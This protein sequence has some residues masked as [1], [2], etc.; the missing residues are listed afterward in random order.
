LTWALQVVATVLEQ[1]LIVEFA[2]DHRLRKELHV[3]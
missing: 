2:S 3:Q 1:H